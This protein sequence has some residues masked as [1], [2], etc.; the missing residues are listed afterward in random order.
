MPNSL[1]RN[2]LSLGRSRAFACACGVP[3]FLEN[4]ACLSCHRQLG[5]E[6]QRAAVVALHATETLGQW[7]IESEGNGDDLRLARRYHRCTNYHSAIACNWLRPVDISLPHDDDGLCLACSLTRTIPDQAPSENRSLWL[8]IETAKR[9]LVRQLLAMGL[10]VATLER[11]PWQDDKRGLAFDFLLTTDPLKPIMTG[12]AHGVITLD[13]QEADDVVREAN[14]KAMHEPYRTLLGHMRHEVA[15]YY[16]DRLVAGTAWLPLFRQ[17]FGDERKDY[18]S[19]LQTHYAIGAPFD[20]AT[21][22]VSAY[23]SCHPWEDWAETWAHYLH[24]RDGMDTARSFGLEAADIVVDRVP[25][26]LGSLWDSQRPGAQSYLDFVNNWLNI[27]AVLNELSGSMGERDFYPFV[28][29]AAAV[30]KLQLVHE[31]VKHQEAV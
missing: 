27:T 28:L 25:Y 2:P 17:V 13:A 16:W 31:I 20:W 18:A 19:A 5:Y 22:H 10:P 3:V 6:H 12:H 24:M 4:S 1:T 14:R 29:P 15:H 23:A 21:R 30:A 8:S 9:R 26:T 7:T 11:S